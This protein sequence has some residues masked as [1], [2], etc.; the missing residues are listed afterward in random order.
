MLLR[1]ERK[2][3]KRRRGRKAGGG[4]SQGYPSPPANDICK[5]PVTRIPALCPTSLPPAFRA[6]P[7]CAV[8]T[9]SPRA[10]FTILF[11]AWTFGC[12][13]MLYPEDEICTYQLQPYKPVLTLWNR[14]LYYLRP[15]DHCRA[16]EF[17]WSFFR[18]VV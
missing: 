4:S 18:S 5:F 11:A 10:D 2:E 12:T 8:T 1:E 13:S 6:K 3:R 15:F 7:T 17:H 9:R 16:T 14:I